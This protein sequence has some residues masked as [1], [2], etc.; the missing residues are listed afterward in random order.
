MDFNSCIA[1]ARTLTPI[2]VD[3][4]SQLAE[5]LVSSHM[6]FCIGVSGNRD[7]T[8]SITLPEPIIAHQA[9]Q[10]LCTKPALQQLL[11][12]L[13]S[14]LGKG[15]AME[16]RRGEVVASIIMLLAVGSIY[17][18]H[19]HSNSPSKNE[20]AG[21]A[22]THEALVDGREMKRSR[23]AAAPVRSSSVSLAAASSS[24][25][26]SPAASSS[27][28]WSLLPPLQ[29]QPTPKMHHSFSSMLPRANVRDFLSALLGAENLR[30]MFATLPPV[31]KKRKISQPPNLS[32]LDACL[33]FRQF[34][35][36]VGTPN[37]EDLADAFLGHYALASKHNAK[38]CDFIIPC[39]LPEGFGP[40]VSA[41]AAHAQR[42]SARISCIFV[43]IK[44]LQT[45]SNEYVDD[46]TFKL[47]N[48]FC[49]G[50]D[51]LVPA[52]P[53]LS[54]YL[55]VGS[56]D[57]SCELVK[58]KIHKTRNQKD[59][60]NNQLCIA[61]FGIHEDA[62]WLQS[63]FSQSTSG[64]VSNFD[65]GEVW[66]LICVVSVIVATARV[67]V[68]KHLTNFRQLFRHHRQ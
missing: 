3:V 23:K 30:S 59:R 36:A 20:S 27:S 53:Y 28:S 40:E 60:L 2:S 42:F 17:A 61:A 58:P 19:S 55:Q 15:I 29:P 7:A 62:P 47:S 67:F 32:I 13:E 35:P 10:L 22:S 66:V 4:F 8:F 21:T 38:G 46:V 14:S 65:V 48:E 54:L 64:S 25:L 39:L 16:G 50:S 9:L 41:H 45:D 68:S 1:L 44:N 52:R 5:H 18:S 56:D 24:S 43:S 63:V 51:R 26:S 31:G 37:V 49:L 33:S 57:T 34:I 11:P 6:A 12:Y